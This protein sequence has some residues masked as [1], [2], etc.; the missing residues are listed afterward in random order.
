IATSAG[1]PLDFDIERKGARV[2]V[3]ATPAPR[4]EPDR[5][6]NVH[7]VGALDLSGPIMPARVMTI[8]PSSAAAE[9]GFQPGDP[10]RAI[11]GKAIA[12]FVDLRDVVAAN[13]E[14]ALDFTIDRGGQTIHIRATPAARDEK[15]ANGAIKRVGQLGIQGGFDPAD[16]RTI[17]YGLLA[18]I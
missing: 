13:P 14:K 18:S 1:R 6:G 9:A 8:Q 15:G 12:S 5:F 11:D 7:R 17:H 10:I 3:K 4:E 16:T 2:V